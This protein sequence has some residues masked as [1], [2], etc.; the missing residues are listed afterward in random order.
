MY[1]HSLENAGVYWRVVIPGLVAGVGAWRLGTVGK[2][3][4]IWM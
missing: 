4:T 1:R 2:M 3:E